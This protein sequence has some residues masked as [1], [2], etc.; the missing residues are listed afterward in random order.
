MDKKKRMEDLVKGI[1]EA[2]KSFA[3][4]KTSKLSDKEYNNA[5]QELVGLEFELGYKLPDSP[6][7][8]DGFLGSLEMLQEL[9]NGKG[10]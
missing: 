5:V 1:L 3:E 8:A 7:Q 10:E 4:T 9:T 2:Q 6:T